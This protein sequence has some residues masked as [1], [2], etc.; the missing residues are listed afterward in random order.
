MNLKDRTVSLIAIGIVDRSAVHG[1]P[2]SVFSEGL[3]RQISAEIS[4]PP[5]RKGH[6][7]RWGSPARVAFFIFLIG[8]VEEPLVLERF[9]LRDTDWSAQAQGPVVAPVALSRIRAGREGDGR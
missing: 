4:V 1:I 7:G 9:Q 5:L 3:I 6:R 8:G 2:E